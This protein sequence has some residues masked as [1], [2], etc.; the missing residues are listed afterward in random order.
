[1]KAPDVKSIS[2]GIL[3]GSLLT[4]CIFLWIDRGKDEVEQSAR[5][6]YLDGRINLLENG[7]LNILDS[8]SV[9][10]KL[11]SDLD[12]KETNVINKYYEENTRIDSL[13][14]T[15]QWLLLRRNLDIAKQRESGGFFAAPER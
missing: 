8:I 6:A 13:P 14:P 11:L 2:L 5:E 7:M 12:I 10:N 1:M 9:N 3:A 4:T 15:E